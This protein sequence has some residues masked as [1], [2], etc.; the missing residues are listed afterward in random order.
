MKDRT[1]R[2]VLHQR[3]SATPSP[4]VA[5]S[6]KYF[7][8]E[9]HTSVSQG[10]VAVQYLGTPLSQLPLTEPSE[11]LSTHRPPNHKVKFLECPIRGLL[12]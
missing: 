2:Y 4:P 6:S 1:Q 10:L 12:V 7:P 8:K 3:F 9:K 11:V 5:R